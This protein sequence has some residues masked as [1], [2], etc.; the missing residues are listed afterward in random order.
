MDNKEGKKIKMEE[1]VLDFW[2]NNKIFQKS[3]DRPAPK[4]D[5]V[6]Y[7]GPPFATGTPHYGHIVGQIMKD[8][9]PRFF[10]MKGYRVERKWGWDCHGLPIENIVEKEMNIK[11]KK[12]I[13]EMGVDKFNQ[14]CRSKV[15]EYAQ[16]WYRVSDKLGRFVDQKNAY[17]TM[18][19]S[20]MESIWWVFKS[21]WDKDLIYKDY[22]SMHVCPRCET[23]LSQSE[24]AEGYAD[25]KDLSCIAKFE[26]EDELGTF[27]L[28]WTTTPWTLIGNTALAVGQEIDYVKI[29]HTKEDGEIEKYILAKERLEDVIKE[30]KYDLIDSFKGEKLLGKKY[31]PLFNYYVNDEKIEKKENAWKIY[32][33]D[34]VTIEDGTGVVH[35]APAFGQDD[36]NLGKE[37]NLPFI[38]HL[39]ID[40]YF[41]DEVI[42][43]KGLNVKPSGDHMSTD[44][45]II[46]YLAGKNLLFDKAKYE[47]SYP[48][49]W[50]CDT[51]LINYATSSWFV[52]VTKIKDDLLRE[53]K[54]IN[55]SPDYL[56]EGRFGNWLEGARD[57]SISRQRFWASV[58]P[59]WECA[60]GERKVFG[61]V[62]D[63]EEASGQKIA[64]I[65]K[66]VVDKIEFPCPVC[67][68]K[69]KRV[70]DVLDCWF[71]SGSM[72]YAQLHYPFANKEKFEKNFPAEF[73][74]EG[75]DQTRAWFYYLHV[76]AVG[77]FGKNAYKNVVVNGMV[78]AED[79]K[80]M[81]KRLQ[82]Y[83][84]PIMIIDKYGAD[85]LRAYLL[86]SPVVRAENFNF[87]EKGT[88]EALRKNIML[89]NNI[90]NFY[91][92][93]AEDLDE[94]DYV[95]YETSKNVLDLW[96]IVKINHLIKIV[97]DSM[98]AYNL[99]KSMRPITEFI[100]EFST[101]YLRR[102]RDRLKG[103]DIEEKKTALAVMRFVFINLSKVMAPFMPFIAE[104]LWQ[105]VNNLNFSD[106][107]KSVHLESWPNYQVKDGENE[108]IETMDEVRKV[109]ELGLAER[110]KAGIKVRQILGGAKVFANG[111]KI[112]GKKEY[113]DLIVE[114]L[115][116]KGV[117]V[118]E[119]EGDI[120]VELD[121]NI[122]SELKMEGAKRELIRFINLRRKDLGLSINDQA[123]VIIS[124]SDDF[125]KEVL[126]KFA[127][128]IK[129]ETL[130]SDIS[131]G[132]ISEEEGVKIRV[133][134]KEIIIALS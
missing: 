41:K 9:F 126:A 10:T 13:E 80:K 25:I 115:N 57:W 98:L 133:D 63:L 65:H 110:D 37:N 130:S 123:K 11:T 32:S 103:D 72:P 124:F 121:T 97:E 7:D 59:I 47:H 128:D 81:A 8:V 93:Y 68:G 5:Y 86:S 78:L 2:N 105:K 84:D 129:K 4:G 66:D 23:T 48:H 90:Y 60:C 75:I 61:S 119:E 36:M 67:A 17:H 96:I 49:C 76:I 73:I 94:I 16:E 131:L 52:N 92:M 104:D 95:K 12:D 89:L 120:R 39:N 114:E 102:S 88:E 29:S 69:M 70:P 112:F 34:F 15:L 33:A 51:P 3:V 106:S 26:L 125:I 24:V 113:L 118:I 74:A 55:W 85:S 46:K 40:G 71:E 22:R 1:Q 42:D 62:K 117:D 99:N 54:N 18:D 28:A 83:P 56:K 82:N 30:K 109:V 27:V 101:W 58:M 132:N 14:T 134:N 108:I 122:S 50:R 35:I 43:F 91:Q 45:E 6:F 53:A 111:L 38:Q 64:D 116:I 19:L 107:E 100:D 44:I 77:L 127:E 31:K 21:L 20:F 87:A 79:G